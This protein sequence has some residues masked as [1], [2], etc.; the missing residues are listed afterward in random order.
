M[1][2]SLVHSTKQTLEELKD[3]ISD[4][5]K[6]TIESAVN[7][8]EESIKGD[9]LRHKRKDLRLLIQ[10]GNFSLIFIKQLPEVVTSTDRVTGYF[11][12]SVHRVRLQGFA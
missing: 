2:D 6:S 3:E 8:L 9:E 1:A 4:E 7:E 12:A 10:E 5:E 11:R